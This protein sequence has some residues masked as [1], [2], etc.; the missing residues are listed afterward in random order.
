MKAKRYG[1]FVSL[2]TKVLGTLLLTITFPLFLLGYF[3]YSQAADILM[4][5]QYATSLNSL[6]GISQSIQIIMDNVREISL[7]LIQDKDVENLLKCKNINSTQA[8]E[9]YNSVVQRTAFYIG[10]KRYLDMIRLYN[11]TVDL[12]N[13]SGNTVLRT[14]IDAERTERVN[15]LKGGQLWFNEYLPYLRQEGGKYVISMLRNVNALNNPSEK[16]GVLRIDIKESALASLF[17]NEV[18]TYEG[19]LY[20]LDEEGK[21]ISSSRRDVLGTSI[22]GI[23]PSNAIQPNAVKQARLANGTHLICSVP[24]EGSDWQLVNVMPINAALRGMSRVR[25]LLFIYAF[26]S[27]FFC[28]LLSVTASRLFVAP[29]LQLA[30]SMRTLKENNY[31]MNL[32]QNRNDEIG[33]LYTSFNE[34]CAKLDE[35]INQVF[36]QKLHREEAELKALQAQINPH[37]LY[38]NLDTAYWMSRIE[39]ADRTGQIV[40]ALSNLFKL[41]IRNASQEI[42]VHTELEH[43]RNYMVIQRIRFENTVDF[44]IDAGTDTLSLQTSRFILQPLVE[45]ALYHGILP[46]NRGGKICIR[47]IRQEDALIFTVE[48]DGVGGDPETMNALLTDNSQTDK[49]FAIRNVHQRIALRCGEGFGLN[50][51]RNPLGGITVTIRQAL[52]V[53]ESETQIQNNEHK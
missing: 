20:L 47:V 40:L 16:L 18:K 52:I 39:G 13:M 7:Q 6:S 53:K 9:A 36:E 45:N 29:I 15:E 27:I 4:E 50:Y 12:Y 21:I 3:F 23:L 24:V 28:I 14:P 46:A 37:F 34:L 43:V 22:D 1:K 30:N 10:Q 31:K 38:N 42:S 25:N 26:I 35:L 33:V 8:S 5:K 19:T 32:K 44:E 41:S 48:D 11:D 17:D 2:R 49:G 51:A